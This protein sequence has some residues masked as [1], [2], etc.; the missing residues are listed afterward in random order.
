M[1]GMLTS[2]WGGAELSI[3]AELVGCAAIFLMFVRKFLYR[4]ADPNSVTARMMVTAQLITINR[5]IFGLGCLRGVV[6]GSLLAGT[7]FE[8]C[9]FFLPSAA[10]ADRNFSNFFFIRYFTLGSNSSLFERLRILC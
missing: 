10:K 8:F 6:T 5:S 9:L 1:L 4:T 7:S 3:A 2:G